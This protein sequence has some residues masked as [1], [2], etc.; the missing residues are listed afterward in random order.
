V[1]SPAPGPIVNPLVSSIAI[2]EVN[3]AAVPIPP[4]G[5]FGE[6]DLIVPAPGP[7]TF[8]LE[9][10]GVP[11]GTNVEV[12]LKPRVASPPGVVTVVQAVTL[13]SGLC[14]ANGRCFPSATLDLAAGAYTAEARATFQTP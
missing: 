2:T 12:T 9:T 8:D 11:T 5:V 10:N 14:D 7:V 1:R 6:V 13:T 3:G 4:Q